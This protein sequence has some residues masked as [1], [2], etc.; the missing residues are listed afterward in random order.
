MNRFVLVVLS[1]ISPLVALARTPPESAVGMAGR[2]EQIVLPGAELVP[3]AADAKSKVVLRVLAVYPHGSAFRYDLEFVGLEPGSYD[4]REFLVRKNGSPIAAGDLPP[5][6]VTIHSVLPP[7]QV[8]PHPLERGDA[9]HVGGY[10]TLGIAAGV[11]W[12]AGLVAILF[13]RRQRSAEAIARSTKPA[14]LADRLKPL[15][16]QAIAGT[17]PAP[18]CASLELS[19]VTLWRRRLGLE[20]RD[21]AEALTILRAHAEAGPLLTGLETW[22]HRPPEQSS[23]DLVALLA[24]YRNL[25][26]EA[27][28]APV[29]A[30]ASS[31]T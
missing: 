17:L 24:P 6:P 10:K 31:G 29:R 3:V 30:G 12:A 7:G 16:E 4:L 27:L 13:Y 5:I 9:P 1:M 25:P 18:Q 2:I 22:L 28:D 19:L 11:V 23:V 8:L 14:T 15:V 20:D 26:P 21:P